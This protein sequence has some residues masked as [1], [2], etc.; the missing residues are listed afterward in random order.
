M[1]RSNL[2]RQASVL[3]D[4]LP[5]GDRAAATALLDDASLLHLPGRSGLAGDYQ[6]PEAILGLLRRTTE[7]TRETMDF[8]SLRVVAEDARVLVLRGRIGATRLGKR[9]DG[10]VLHVLSLRDEKIREAWILSLNQDHF[11][12]FWTGW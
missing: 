10:E 9:L 3:Y 4:A 5:G 2:V 6:G 1:I 7:L 8:G 12:D 11:D